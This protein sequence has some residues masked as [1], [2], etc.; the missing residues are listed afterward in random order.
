MQTQYLVLAI[1]YFLLCFGLSLIFKKANVQSL[2]AWIP[3]YNFFVW[4]KLIEKPWWWFLLLLI[5]GVN[6]LMLAVYAVKTARSFGKNSFVEHAIASLLPYVYLIY[7][8]SS[9]DYLFVGPPDESKEKR[10]MLQEWGDAIVFAVV[11]ASV[12]RTFFLEAFTIPTSSLEKTLMVGD[13]LF[14]S[15]VSYGAKVPN[16]PLSFPFAHHTLPG[17]ENTK[18]YLDWITFP[19]MRL[20][21]LG[22]VKNNDLVVFNYP[23]GDT[24]AQNAQDQS[25]YQLC[26]DYG[27]DRVWKNADINQMTG[28]P[29]F[30]K[31]VA[32]PPDKREN[33]I[34]RCI[35]IAGDTIL[36]RNRNL[37]INGKRSYESEHMQYSY[38][39]KAP[40]GLNP[41]VLKQKLDITDQIQLV[42]ENGDYV[43]MLPNDKVERMKQFS[44]VQSVIPYIEDSGEYNPRV[45]P[46]SPNYKWNADFFGPLVVPKKGMTVT[47]DTTNIKLYDRIIEVYEHNKLQINNGK[48]FINDIETNQY[49]FKL[50]HYFMMGD[51]RH[52]SADSRFWGFVPEDHIVG[53]AVFVWMS[54][55]EGGQSFLKRFRVERLFTF[56]S[57]DGLSRSY[58]I[59]FLILMGG[60]WGYNRF[61]K[62][63]K[64]DDKQT[65][66]KK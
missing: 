43:V 44:G 22:H 60:I 61:V 63:K 2:K 12:L 35:A 53:K 40:M 24:V 4:T 41:E 19:Y 55:K 30:G 6:F 65:A 54:L 8:G 38:I 13:Y 31:V 14:V 5:P 46:H 51:N 11:A 36:I 66:S 15:K 62:K 37:F 29:I 7:I 33:Y 45:F 3:F 34:K 26:R 9:K 32:R 58:F 47:L 48:I 17:T 28:K 27:R 39:V 25:Y 23:D 42:S 18:S 64:V 49:T 59:H 16:T 21:G 56:V 1:L 57:D 20:P 50:D 52:N 10:S